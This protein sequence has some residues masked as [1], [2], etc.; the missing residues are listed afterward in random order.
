MLQFNSSEK[1]K[2]RLGIFFDYFLFLFL[3]DFDDY[4]DDSGIIIKICPCL[5]SQLLLRQLL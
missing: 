5:L 3:L 1:M 2:N 4:D